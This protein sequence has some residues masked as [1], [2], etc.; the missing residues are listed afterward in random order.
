ME[1]NKSLASLD[2]LIIYSITFL[3][4]IISTVSLF[5]THGFEASFNLW[6]IIILISTIPFF[7]A[8]RAINV[9]RVLSGASI[10]LLGVQSFVLSTFLGLFELTVLGLFS[11]LGIYVLVRGNRRFKQSKS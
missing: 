4:I 7:F 3:F 2:L 9:G 10:I 1:K 5:Y 6:T 8:F 11:A